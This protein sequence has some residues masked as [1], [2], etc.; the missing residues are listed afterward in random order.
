MWCDVMYVC[1]Y[2]YIYIHLTLSAPKCSQACGNPLL[3]HGVWGCLIWWHYIHICLCVCVN[4]YIYTIY[5]SIYIYTFMYILYLV[6]V[7]ITEWI[8][9]SW[10]VLV[11]MLPAF[12]QE[13]SYSQEVIEEPQW[14]GEYSSKNSGGFWLDGNNIPIFHKGASIYTYIHIYTCR[15]RY[16]DKRPW[17]FGT[18]RQNFHYIMRSGVAGLMLRFQHVLGTSKT[19]LMLRFCCS[20]SS[21]QSSCNRK[22]ADL[23]PTCIR[24]WA[25]VA[26]LSFTLMVQKAAGQS[27][28]PSTHHKFKK[29]MSHITKMSSQ[30]RWDLGRNLG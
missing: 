4:I 18:F 16:V 22:F 28:I 6:L 30:R 1:M 7:Y 27:G 19:L 10:C 2:V 11:W 23:L 20:S 25:T 26:R 14:R 5:M 24:I 3:N 12:N 15:W 8:P 13:R 29:I 17:R 21:W 9:I